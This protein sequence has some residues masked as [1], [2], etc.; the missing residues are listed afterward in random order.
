MKVLICGASPDRINNNAILRNYVAQGF[1]QVLG[2]D[3]VACCSL[4]IANEVAKLTRPD[5]VLVF[6]SCMPESCDYTGVRNYCSSTG[7]ALAFWLHDD[8]YEFDLNFKIYKYADYIFSNDRWA[9]EHINHKNVHHLPLAADQKSHFLNVSE[10]MVRDVFFCGV[11]FPNRVQ[12]L[13]DSQDQLSSLNTEVLGAEWP[14]TLRFATNRRVPN[15]KMSGLYNTSLVT[16]N[17]G[18]R[19]NLANEK[20]NLD[21]STPGPRTFEAAMAGTVQC[22]F[23][24][25][26]EI[27]EYYKPGDEILLFDSPNELKRIVEELLDDPAKRKMI[28]EK[29]QARTLKDHTYAN[30]AKA[31]L[32]NIK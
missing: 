1:R 21:A 32:L 15:E 29:S 6:G 19:H 26:L 9:V 27:T 10:M 16:L 11:G 5:L 3:L 8:P 4:D 22:Y 23:V 18:R 20:Y 17:L 2:D 28:A 24:E 13:I 31:I 25:G 30:R 7:A 14:A 12:L